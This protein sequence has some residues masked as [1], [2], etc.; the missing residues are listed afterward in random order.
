MRKNNGNL[1]IGFLI[2]SIIVFIIAI[3]FWVFTNSYS[4]ENHNKENNNYVSSISTT[5]KIDIVEDE[6][7]NIDDTDDENDINSWNSK[8]T[9]GNGNTILIY[10]SGENTLDVDIIN[11]NVSK[12]TSG[13][14]M[15]EVSSNNK[16][17]YTETFFDDT[18]NLTLT[19]NLNEMELICDSTDEDSVLNLASGT[20]YKEDFEKNGWDGRYENGDDTIIL[21]ETDSDTLFIT[22]NNYWIRY[23]DERDDKQINY[24]DSF[25]GNLEEM[26]IEKTADGIKITSS[27][28]DEDEDILN[29]ISGKEF[30]FVD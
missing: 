19:R 6:S 7:N 22:I 10:R 21:A 28:T 18:D 11:T 24:E 20:Y 5:N 9:D 15:V 12:V 17:E 4:K 13:S 26:K 2:L 23:A 27:S 25:F 30:E 29:E 14:Y 3:L 8:Y 16:I 1:S